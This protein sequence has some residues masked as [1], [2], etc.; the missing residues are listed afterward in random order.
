[1]ARGQTVVAVEGGRELR[2]RLRTV[3]GGLEDLKT[4][5]R[6]VAT[7]VLGR[8]RPGAPRRTGALAANGRASGT[9]TMSTVR[10]GSVRVPYAAPIHYGWPQR[11]IS[12]H[13]WV[14]T[15]A[16]QSEAVWVAH[17]NQTIADLVERTR[18]V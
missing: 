7:Y 14:I 5:H 10:Y 16:Q 2:R 9:K 8:A 1:M 4:E 18:S 15:A 13:P 12:P 3:E 6:W 11:H 17:F